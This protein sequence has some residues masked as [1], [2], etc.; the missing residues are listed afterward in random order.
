MAGARKE[1]R[2]VKLKVDGSQEEEE[3]TVDLDVEC[4]FCGKAVMA[5]SRRGQVL[6]A[7]PACEK[8]NGPGGPLDFLVAMRL[9]RENS[10]RN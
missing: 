3:F 1:E 6:H 2:A 4:A 8:F 9:H 7:E 5:D 10:K